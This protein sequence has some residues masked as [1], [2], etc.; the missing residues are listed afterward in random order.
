MSLGGMV[1]PYFKKPVKRAYSGLCRIKRG[2]M[3]FR[4]KIQSLVSAVEAKQKGRGGDAI[5]A[6]V[7]AIGESNV[8]SIGPMGTGKT[9]LFEL[10]EKAL[11]LSWVQFG[12]GQSSVFQEQ[13]NAHSELEDVFGALDLEEFR[14]GTYC[15]VAGAGIQSA[16]VAL[17]DEADKGSPAIQNAM[18]GIIHAKERAM[19]DNGE[20]H[21]LPLK[22][23]YLTANFEEDLAP[24]FLA[25]CPLRAPTKIAKE[26]LSATLF[27][28]LSGI[29]QEPS[30]ERFTEA[31]FRGI[32]DKARELCASASK[33]FMSICDAINSLLKTN[34]N[35]SDTP[36]SPRDEYNMLW[37][38]AIFAALMGADKLDTKHLGFLV[39]GPWDKASYNKCRKDIITN[40]GA[41]DLTKDNADWS[42]L[43]PEDTVLYTI[44]YGANSTAPTV[45]EAL[46]ATGQYWG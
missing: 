13:L 20:R 12:S 30:I 1:S 25:R 7:A 19:R 34:T 21:K 26:G 11:P 37:L 16:T 31:D 3:Q 32:R 9:E 35:K 4:S 43:S 18:L 44:L 22:F 33:G 15:R 17:I 2:C 8:L 27:E 10:L 40:S 6:L 42:Q 46:E 23:C 5:V 29:K 14:E 28:R 45:D 41:T 39:Y 24:A 38:T 36:Y